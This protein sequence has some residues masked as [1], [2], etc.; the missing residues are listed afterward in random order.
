MGNRLLVRFVVVA[1]A[2][3]LLAGCAGRTPPADMDVVADVDLQRYSGR[4]YEIARLPNKFQKTCAGNVTAD[5]EPLEDGRLRVINRCTSSD[6][7][8]QS[9]EGVARMADDNPAQLEVRFAPAFLGWLPPVWGDYWIL[10]LGSGPRYDYALVGEPSREYLWILSR[11][12]TM[13][14]DT[15]ASLLKHAAR[16]GYDVTRVRRTPQDDLGKTARAPR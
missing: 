9:A 13:D 6:G 10:E 2:V 12:R 16:Q 14:D 11:T 3:G 4:W 1:G 7:S 15:Y 5:Y 8:E